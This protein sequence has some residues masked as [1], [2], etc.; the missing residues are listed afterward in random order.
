MWM[1]L[2]PKTH[3]MDHIMPLSC[4]LTSSTYT[5]VKHRYIEFTHACH[6]PHKHITLL[7]HVWTRKTSYPTH[8]CEPARAFRCISCHVC[9]SNNI[10]SHIYVIYHLN[11][12][13]PQDGLHIMWTFARVTCGGCRGPW[14]R[15]T[16]CVSTDTT[17]TTP[18]LARWRT[19]IAQLL[20]F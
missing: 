13:L 10:H 14:L 7:P 17:T 9:D 20:S 12:I 5:R 11:P 3:I 18:S 4:Y 16:R 2:S 15:V 6:R 1:Q 8:T 19:R